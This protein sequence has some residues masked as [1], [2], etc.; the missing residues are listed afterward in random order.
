MFSSTT[1]NSRARRIVA[2][3]ACLNLL[4]FVVELVSA[5]VIGS[6]SLFADA[7][8]FLEDTLINLLVLTAL[9]WSVTS[10]RKASIGLAGLILIPALAAFG[11]VVWKIFSGQPPEPWSLSA[12][13]VFAMAINVASAA[14]LMRLRSAEVTLVRGA[15]LAARN[16]VLANILI[17]AA[18]VV[19]VFWF[20]VWPDIVVGLIIAAINVTAAKEVYEQARADDPQL[21]LEETAD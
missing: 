19:T 2:V 4:G 17:L 18:G 15:W 10:R 16:D 20:S 3:V 9:G 21:E 13:A 6:A 5:T 1:L 12:V 8:D 11:T 14:L 7:A